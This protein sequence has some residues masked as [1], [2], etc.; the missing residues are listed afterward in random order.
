MSSIRY[1]SLNVGISR[2]RSI[3]STSLLLESYLS[4]AM[5]G[6]SSPLHFSHRTKSDCAIR[7]QS[8]VTGRPPSLLITYIDCQIPTTEEQDLYQEGEVPLGC[9]SASYV[10]HAFLMF[11]STGSWHLGIQSKREMLGA[12]CASCPRREASELRKR[13]GN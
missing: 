9:K 4:S 5:A 6:M 2:S 3:R 7:W 12:P 1:R 13:H 8:L 11:Y 10:Q